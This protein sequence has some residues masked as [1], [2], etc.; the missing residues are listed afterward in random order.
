VVEPQAIALR[1]QFGAQQ[2]SPQTVIG[3]TVDVERGWVAA[4]VGMEG[5]AQL[6]PALVELREYWIGQEAQDH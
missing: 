3:P 4:A 5:R 6:A 2:V 1:A